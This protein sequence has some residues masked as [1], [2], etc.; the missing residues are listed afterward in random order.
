MMCDND[1]L[2]PL[3]QGAVALHENFSAHV[4]A[5][6]TRPE[7]LEIVLTVMTEAMR[8]NAEHQGHSDE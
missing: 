2:T 8:L 5:G 7:A 3:E 6:F 4:R 1:A